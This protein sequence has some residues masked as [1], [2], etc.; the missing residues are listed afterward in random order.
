MDLAKQGKNSNFLTY[1]LSIFYLL[2]IFL[3][4]YLT[5]LGLDMGSIE[6]TLKEFI[7]LRNLLF[8]SYAGVLIIIGV[9]YV[10]KHLSKDDL[11]KVVDV[12]IKNIL[13]TTFSY[14]IAGYLLAFSRLFLK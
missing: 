2:N 7:R 12:M 4:L 5:K 6:S 1:L 9:F 13:L 11:L 8:K 14:S 10:L 3:I